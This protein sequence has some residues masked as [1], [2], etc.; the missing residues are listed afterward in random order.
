M[1]MLMFTVSDPA[2]G[3]VE[4]EVHFDEKGLALLTDILRQAR[5]TGHE[6][7]FEE[8]HFLDGLDIEEDE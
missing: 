5:L 1:P 8:S 6:H 7:V 2:G 3:D 4:L